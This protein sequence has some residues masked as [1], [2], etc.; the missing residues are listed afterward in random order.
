MAKH[1][2]RSGQQV[3]TISW[4][5]PDARH[6]DWSLDT[7]VQAVVDA[8]DAVE[9]ITGAD[10]AHVL[11][12]CAGGIVSSCALAHLAAT[13]RLDRIAGLTLGVTVLDNE[14]SGTVS[15]FVDPAVAALAV[16]ESARRGYL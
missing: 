9:R 6:R 11:G 3:F 15:A 14:R 7:Y 4:R 2:L 16:A 10:R 12:L 13:D 1:L 8:L 5:N